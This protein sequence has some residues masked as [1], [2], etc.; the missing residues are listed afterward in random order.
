M[1]CLFNDFSGREISRHRSLI[2]CYKA[3]A[4]IDRSLTNGSYLPMSPRRIVKGE[5]VRLDDGEQQK[6]Y[7]IDQKFCY[8]PLSQ[9]R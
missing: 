6:W 7:A 1:Y 8:S 2:A 4:R 3:K 5:L 9:I